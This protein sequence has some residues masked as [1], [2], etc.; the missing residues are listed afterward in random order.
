MHAR[1]T[2]L[3]TIVS[4]GFYICFLLSSHAVEETQTLLY[5]K[6]KKHTNL[7]T[8]INVTYIHNTH[9]DG[10]P[11]LWGLS[12]PSAPKGGYVTTITTLMVLPSHTHK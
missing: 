9:L 12:L 5:L 1:F 4:L 2:K 7:I 10:T 8:I 3:N 6:K 11:P